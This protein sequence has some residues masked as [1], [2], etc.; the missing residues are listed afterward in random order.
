MPG[1]PHLLTTDEQHLLFTAVCHAQTEGRFVEARDGYLLLLQYA[2]DAVPLHYNI[3]LVYYALGVFDQALQEFSQALIMDPEDADILFNLALC[4][5]K[6]GDC[7]AAIIS[8]LRTLEIIPDSTDC[9]YN[10]AGCYRDSHEYERAVAGYLRV[11]EVDAG[12]LPAINNLAYL[13]HR[14]G[15]TDQ[16]RVWYRRVLALRPEDDA[17]RYMLASLVGTPCA[18]APES[19][20]RSFFDAYAEGF[21][22]SLVTELGYDNPRKL[23]ECLER[24]PERKA[25]YEHGLDLGCG[26]GLSGAAFIATVLVLDGVD[27]SINMLAQAARKGCYAELYSDSI[28]HYLGVTAETYDFFLATDVLIY[29][30]DLVDLFKATAAIAR[31]QALFCFST[32]HLDTGTYHLQATGRYAYSRAYVEEVA[33]ASGWIVLALEE[34]DLRK[35]R[36]IWIAGDLWVLRLGVAER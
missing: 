14:S 24:C 7:P 6:T 18:H 3:G 28:G 29:I 10:L 31:P 33:A 22:F 36:D 30:G 23:Y 8:Y 9:L 17:A 11:L 13:C 35:E 19:Y 26:T 2:P 4:Q 15:D 25:I 32:E 21:E 12:Y 1:T 16:A 34:T 5:K 27:L 20:V